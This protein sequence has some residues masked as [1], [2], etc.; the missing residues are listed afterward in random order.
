M[1]IEK[2]GGE[3]KEKREAK[4]DKVH[5]KGMR[6]GKRKTKKLCKENEENRG[7]V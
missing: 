3:S 5:N 4:G 6:E 1:E 7:E 2:V